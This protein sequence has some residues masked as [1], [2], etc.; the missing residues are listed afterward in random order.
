MR[1]SFN[2]KTDGMLDFLKDNEEDRFISA[3]DFIRD[4]IAYSK[5]LFPKRGYILVTGDILKNAADAN[6]TTVRHLD[7]SKNDI[8][9]ASDLGYINLAD[10]NYNPDDLADLTGATVTDLLHTI[11]SGIYEDELVISKFM[12]DVLNNKIP[13]DKAII[14]KINNSLF[15]RKFLVDSF[16]DTDIDFWEIAKNAR[17]RAWR[18]FY[19]LGAGDTS[20]SHDKLL[21]TFKDLASNL[22]DSYFQTINCTIENWLNDCFMPALRATAVECYTD[23]IYSMDYGVTAVRDVAENINPRILK[24]SLINLKLIVDEVPDFDSY[25]AAVNSNSGINND[26]ANCLQFL[27]DYLGYAQDSDP[28]AYF[29][30]T[31]SIRFN[32][33]NEDCV[34]LPKDTPT[35]A[36]LSTLQIWINSYFEV[37][38]KRS[39]IIAYRSNGNGY[40]AE[41]QET[42][43]QGD[44]KKDIDSKFIIQKIKRFYNK[45]VVSTDKP[46]ADTHFYPDVRSDKKYKQ[47][48]VTAVPG[49]HSN[50]PKQ[51]IKSDDVIDAKNKTLLDR[52]DIMNFHLNEGLVDIKKLKEKVLAELRKVLIKFIKDTNQS[53]DCLTAAIYSTKPNTLDIKITYKNIGT[54][55]NLLLE[56]LNEALI[57]FDKGAVAQL[58]ENGKMILS[59]IDVL[60]NADILERE[61]FEQETEQANKEADD[62]EL[63]VQPVGAQPEAE[64]EQA[65]VSESLLYKYAQDDTSLLEQL[66]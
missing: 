56:V 51:V 61:Q 35:N 3:D 36:Q 52:S 15:N 1:N 57:K 48:E 54:S 41:H 39:L 28:A 45:Y 43:T 4:G 40:D 53:A 29:D 2:I 23:F 12:A 63:D 26:L 13:V 11:K 27:K 22:D 7:S 42:F 20:I 21:D 38:N 65:E 60:R 31:N 50:I 62:A 64:T 33:I 16:L 59:T 30:N 49:V 6:A 8:Q 37:L 19:S 9:N 10:K 44:H 34:M 14:N 46:D 66:F 47:S 25:V 18:R 24:L 5:E 55:L 58:Q 32:A 17:S